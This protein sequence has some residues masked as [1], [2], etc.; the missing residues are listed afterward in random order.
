MR[1]DVARRL[2]CCL[3]LLFPLLPVANGA[4]VGQFLSAVPA[5]LLAGERPAW[6]DVVFVPRV[7]LPPSATLTL[8]AQSPAA[9]SGV[10]AVFANAANASL[11]LQTCTVGVTYVAANRLQLI[12]DSKCT[13]PAQAP[14]A[15]T[16]PGGFLAA[17]PP[18]GTAV[19]LRLRLDGEPD[20]QP[21]AIP[22]TTEAPR[23]G[24]RLVSIGQF[25]LSGSYTLAYNT[26]GLACTSPCGVGCLFFADSNPSLDDLL[27]V[28]VQPGRLVL[29]RDDLAGATDPRALLITC[30]YTLGCPGFGSGSPTVAFVAGDDYHGG[31]GLGLAQTPNA[32]VASPT[33]VGPPSS[34]PVTSF[35]MGIS[36]YAFVA[37]GAL[38]AGGR[39]VYGS[40]YSDGLLQATPA[41]V[42][43][44]NGQAVTE[45]A[46]GANHLGYL[47]GGDL[48]ITGQNTFSQAGVP[49]TAVS[50][51]AYYRQLRL[52][53]SGIVTAVFFGGTHSAFA[54]G[55]RV[56]VFGTSTAATVASAVD[57]YV[58]T[59]L[60]APDN[61]T[62]Q[63]LAFGSAHALMLAGGWVYGI[64]S[65]DEGQLGEWVANA[66]ATF[67]LLS[68]RPATAVA[69]GPSS[70]AFVSGGQLYVAGSNTNGQLG[71][72]AGSPA[73]VANFTAVPNVSGV[74]AVRLWASL[75]V[76][77][78]G[79]LYTCG[80]NGAGQLGLGDFRPR[81][82]LQRVPMPTTQAVVTVAI[83]ADTMVV[84]TQ[85]TVTPT[86]TFTGTRTSSRSATLTATDSATATASRTATATPVPTL[87]PSPT[88][89]MGLVACNAMQTEPGVS[90]ISS[91]G[92][93]TFSADIGAGSRWSQLRY[94]QIRFQELQG[95]LSVKLLKGCPARTGGCP[96]CTACRW[97]Y[98]W[99]TS[100]GPTYW[101]TVAAV[102]R[103]LVQLQFEPAAPWDPAN[104]RLERAVVEVSTVAEATPELIGTVCAVAAAVILLAGA[105][106]W[107][108][109]D[110][111]S[112]TQAG[113]RSNPKLG[114]PAV[115][116]AWLGCAGCSGVG[117]A[118][119]A[120]VMFT[121]EVVPRRMDLM[122]GGIAM[123]AV[124]AAVSLLLL[125]YCCWDGEAHQCPT[126]ERQVS[127]WR[128][129]GVYLP[130]TPGLGG[131]G[132]AKAHRRH[133]A[134]VRCGRAVVGDAWRGS[135]GRRRYH[136]M[137]W[138]AHAQ[139]ALTDPTYRRLQCLPEQRGELAYLLAEAIS[140]AA[141]EAIDFL[142]QTCP[143]LHHDLLPGPEGPTA[144][145][146]A[147]R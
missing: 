34:A 20:D 43:P 112:R 83:G 75:A 58:P 11:S 70:S 146:L 95:Q 41:R 76:V 16:I 87:T 46:C 126:C 128:F 119:S 132:V 51:L 9:T 124:G 125:V 129:V 66:T 104:H 23:C 96:D 109:W 102:D 54:M 24:T 97:N 63:A 39:N 127:R 84:R 50:S 107:S 131:H 121:T 90:I 74:G 78:D 38:W 26:T 18:A 15:L 116:L 29:Y 48:F 12:F 6:L 5:T 25:V 140:A 137:C 73:V 44:A 64:G 100:V 138:R 71:L 61:R 91:P 60:F 2:L 115:R 49:Y 134:C 111:W 52:P 101:Y 4:A 53:F 80:A 118:W 1:L 21:V 139:A 89:T 30:Y 136:E 13:F 69:A 147:A 130:A 14:V 68:W 135:K 93:C 32:F 81:S 3:V 8:S 94:F 92:P 42:A 19:Q 122:A 56:F 62:I 10:L 98:S 28:A 108:L 65:T 55:Q 105:F 72:G 40:G 88:A 82:T 37:G 22:Y 106:G 85:P 67:I 33:L 57:A 113:W 110:W 47:A 17:H 143:G 114:L 133:V 123:A 145:H 117:V 86:S 31:L 99:A 36:V 27:R 77:A 103:V 142:I 45:A 120:A 59:E 7:T 144:T 35:A 79:V 141:E